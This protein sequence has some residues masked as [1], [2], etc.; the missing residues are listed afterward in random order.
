MVRN[1]KP[2]GET[3]QIHVEGVVTWTPGDVNVAE[4]KGG[5]ESI[6]ST[7]EYSAQ[8]PQVII[9]IDKWMKANP[10]SVEHMLEAMVV[11]GDAV[12]SSSEALRR[13]AEVSA[14]VYGEQD[15]S[16]WARYYK[17]TVEKDRTENSVELGGSAVNNLADNMLLFG[18][19]PGS[20]NV[21]GA[22]YRVFGDIVKAQY[23]DLV[24]SYP[25]VD[26]ILDTSYL[27][28]VAQKL[29]FD[30]SQLAASNMTPS[31]IG[32]GKRGRVISSRAWNITFKTGS[33]QFTSQTI[34]TLDKL[35]RDLLVAGNTVVEI[36]GHTDNVGNSDQNMKLSES[37][38]FAVKK[39]LEAK[40]PAQFPA[41]RIRVTAHGQ[42]QPVSPN[43]SGEGRARNRR[44][45]IK[46]GATT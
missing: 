13:G 23:P 7:K 42:T 43:T 33:A 28:A 18:L 15:A 29:N 3:K 21:F 4:K 36:H 38:A 17:G 32:G 25:P 6:V 40:A 5:L 9:G 30:P 26:Q 37:R 41:G 19:A 46:L 39:W 22:T 8:M 1:G 31:K 34:S 45:E 20:A 35:I 10:D 24:P 14:K 12:R 27:R 2:T 11:G 44:V 16:Y